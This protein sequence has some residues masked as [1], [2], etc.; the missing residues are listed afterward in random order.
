MERPVIATNW[1]ANTEFMSDETSYLLDYEV[2]E[3]RGLEPEL[4]HYKGH[5]WAN[6][7]ESHLRTLMRRVFTHPEEARA[8]G[9]AARKPL[10]G[11]L[12][13]ILLILGTLLA[14][15]IMLR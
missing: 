6:P 5:R 14:E 13:P 11:C 10:I 4:W 9:Q 7:S 2:V 1:S 12:L 8:K 3:A 15:E